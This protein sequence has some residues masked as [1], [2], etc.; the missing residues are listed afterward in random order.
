MTKNIDKSILD[1]NEMYKSPV[2]NRYQ[3]IHMNL[4]LARKK[5]K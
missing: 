4:G 2:L 1:V 3:R 5:R